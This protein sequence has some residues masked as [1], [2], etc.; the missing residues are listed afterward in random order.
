LMTKPKRTIQAVKHQMV[1]VCGLGFF[2]FLVAAWSIVRADT[3]ADI[4]FAKV[5]VLAFVAACIGV[6]IHV[7]PRWYAVLRSSKRCTNGLCSTCGYDLRAS[8]E[9]CPECSTEFTPSNQVQ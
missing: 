9:R 3:N 8:T 2:G 1:I 5:C 6:L 4:R 7:V